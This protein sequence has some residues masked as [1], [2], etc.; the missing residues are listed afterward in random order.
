MAQEVLFVVFFPCVGE[1]VHHMNSLFFSL[2]FLKMFCFFNLSF[3]ASVHNGVIIESKLVNTS[4]STCNCDWNF[5]SESS[6][7]SELTLI[8][9]KCLQ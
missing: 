5:F 9:Q 2:N 8:I 4:T 3:R 7:I 1:G 6:D